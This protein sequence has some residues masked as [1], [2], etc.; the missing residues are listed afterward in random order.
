M[1]L[2]GELITTGGELEE[3]QVPLLVADGVLAA[4]IVVV[5]ELH[6]VKAGPAMACIDN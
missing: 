6:K 3:V 4:I 1:G 2:F 5:E